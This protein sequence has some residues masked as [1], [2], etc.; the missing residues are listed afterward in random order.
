MIIC[1]A[2][3]NS[4]GHVRITRGDGFLIAGGNQETH[5]TLQDLIIKLNDKLGKNFSMDEALSALKASDADKL[6]LIESIEVDGI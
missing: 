4:D 2:V 3:G 5:E 6:G 1:R